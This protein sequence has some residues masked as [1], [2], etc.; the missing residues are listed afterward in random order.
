MPTLQ[1]TCHIR[2]DD[3]YTSE[4]TGVSVGGNLGYLM[5][6]DNVYEDARRAAAYAKLEFP[7]TYY[8]AYR[9]L[10]AIIAKH[11]T[12]EKAVDFGCGTGRSTRFLNQLGFAAIGLDIA[13]DMIDKARKIDPNGVYRLIQDGDLSQ[14]Q[15][16]AYDLVLSVFT[17]DNIPTMEK[18]VTIFKGL[19]SL[20]RSE[21]KIINL[22]S[23]PEI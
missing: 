7:G 3:Y 16:N 6:F 10:P 21:G 23:A 13:D 18:K 17:F 14:C 11:I 2:P 20:L 22:V 15:V 5:G 1:L 19:R 8:L 4:L 12:G 9:D